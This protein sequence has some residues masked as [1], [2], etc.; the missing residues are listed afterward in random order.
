MCSDDVT[1]SRNCV[2]CGQ[3]LDDTDPLTAAWLYGETDR[4]ALFPDFCAVFLGSTVFNK[5]NT[6]N[7]F[8]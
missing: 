8:T 6:H 2:D 3:F 5:K 1:V 4:A 7:A